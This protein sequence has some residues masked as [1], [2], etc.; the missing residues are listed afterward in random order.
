MAEE[1]LQSGRSTADTVPVPTEAPTADSTPAKAEKRASGDASVKS[2]KKKIWPYIVT[3]TILVLGVVSY[4]FHVPSRLLD[5]YQTTSVTL[6]IKEGEKFAIE[7]AAVSVDGKSYTSDATGKVTIP[8]IIEG[9]YPITIKKDGYKPL[10][11]ELSVMRGSDELKV[12]SLIKEGEKLFALSGVVNNFVTG[13]AMADV[14]VSL[15]GTTVKTNAAGEYSF[16]KLAAG[17]QKVSF[18]KTGFTVVTRSETIIAEDLKLTTTALSPV[19]KVVFVSNRTGGKRAIYQSNYD[20]TDQALLVTPVG[21]TEDF[22]PKFSPDG[23]YV[24]F[25][26]SRDGVISSFGGELTRLYVVG[27]DGK[28]LKKISDDYSAQSLTWSPT[29]SILFFS[30]YSDTKLSLP[31]SKFYNVG[32]GE[33]YEIEKTATNVTFSQKSEKALYTTYADGVSV[34][35]TV[36]PIT[37]ERTIIS[38]KTGFIEAASWGDAD[39]TVS[40]AYVKP[41]GSRVYYKLQ[42]G[43]NAEAEVAAP[44]STVAT[45]VLTLSPSATQAVFV[46]ER[47]G[48]KDLFREDASGKNEL[49]LT[50]LGVVSSTVQPRWDATG[51]YLTFAVVRENETALYVVSAEGGAAQKITDFFNDPSP[52][53]YA[54]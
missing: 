28:N 12:F 37:G 32:K 22:G 25:S 54:L 30:A 11:A 3:G 53:S 35:R 45:K 20:G 14:E 16:T 38:Q 17:T 26:S 5:M 43:T 19:G 41:D 2:T 15:D 27:K 7:G 46:A 4:A 49:K 47:D 29:G 36:N 13:T 18:G 39:T 34:L 50:S 51:S 40:Y 10:E 44:V 48:K 9:T 1:E 31:V 52:P 23:S 42:V 24:A 21:T 8:A 6:K 33:V